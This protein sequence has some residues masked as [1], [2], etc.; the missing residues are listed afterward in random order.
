MDWSMEEERVLSE[1]REHGAPTSSSGCVV[2][3]CGSS[4]FKSGQEERGDSSHFKSVGQDVCGNFPSPNLNIYCEVARW[5]P[6]KASHENGRLILRSKKWIGIEANQNILLGTGLKLRP[7]ESIGDITY[8][9]M[10]TSHLGSTKDFDTE[11]VSHNACKTLIM[12][13]EEFVIKVK[14]KT[15]NPITI[16]PGEC[17]GSIFAIK[18]IYRCEI[19][20]Q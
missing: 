9:Y 12:L 3:D 11:L 18:P 17:L 10:C 1:I 16:Y 5:S 19:N 6:L 13:D 2:D 14:N 15:Q 4:P 8:H 7:G 20:T